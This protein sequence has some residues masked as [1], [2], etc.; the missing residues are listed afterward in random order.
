[1]ARAVQ[2]KIISKRTKQE[3]QQ[4]RRFINLRDAGISKATQERYYI[5]LTHLLPCLAAIRSLLQLDEKVSDWVQACWE[6]GESLHIVS[7]ALCGLHFF[8]PWTKKGIPTAWRLFATWRKLEFP[9]RAPPITAYI[10]YS[11]ASYAIG[12]KDLSFAVML[13]LGFFGLLRTGELLQ[14]CPNDI[15]VGRK[16]I[17]ISL[18]DTKTG[19]RDNVS[20]MVSFF[21]D[22]TYETL[23][24]FQDFR[25]THKTFLTPIWSFSG[26]HFRD[27]FKRY[28]KKF[29]LL[30]HNFRPY[31]LRRGGATYVFQQTGSMEVAL[32]KGRWGSSR[33]ARIY[34]ADG[35]SFLPGLT[36]TDE[37]TRLLQAWDPFSTD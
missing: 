6:A 1:M 19:K 4:Q 2:W 11:L 17:I 5:G 32:L 27:Q 30:Q 18:F 24:A 26:Q 22:F 23:L 12:H 29:D 13:L 21:D 16:Q 8:E 9:A 20:E 15:L 37:A 33:V 28:L 35:V 3:R 7:D 34:I 36:F 14:L 31:S 10:I 25:R